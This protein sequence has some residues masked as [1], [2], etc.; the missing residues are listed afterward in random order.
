MFESNNSIYLKK[1]LNVFD[2]AAL[3][4]TTLNSVWPTS[5]VSSSSFWAE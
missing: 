1:H 3:P 2:R 4:T 5:V